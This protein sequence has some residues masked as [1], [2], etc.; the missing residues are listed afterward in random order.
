M[1]LP[2]Q[3]TGGGSE[4]MDDQDPDL[5]KFRPLNMYGYSKHLF[6]C[7]AKRRGILRTLVGLKGTFNVF[8]PERESQGRHGAAWST[9][10]SNRSRETR[11]RAALQELPP[12][13]SPTGSRC[14][15]SSTSKMPWTWTISSRGATPSEEGLFN[16]GSGRAHT[17]IELAHAIFRAL[18]IEPRIEFVDMPE[19]L[20][21][22]YQYFTEAN[23]TKLRSTG[24]PGEITPLEDA[25]ARL[26]P[27][28]PDSRCAAGGRASGRC[29]SRPIQLPTEGGCFFQGIPLK[30]SERW[31][32][33][34]AYG[35]KMLGY[36]ATS[37]NRRQSKNTLH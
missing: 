37:A 9:R 22:K 31:L 19:Q 24:Y 7:Y 21:G 28:L 18:E 20:R 16:I 25:S 36:S 35:E 27:E 13:T 8:R 4:G 10:R 34:P 3:P 15:T 12:R 11:R 29:R 17:W 1:P 33:M 5:E 26:R 32:H 23:I 2:P 30:V 6:D 14:A